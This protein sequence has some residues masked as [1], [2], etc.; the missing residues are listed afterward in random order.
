MMHLSLHKKN[1]IFRHG[2]SL[3]ILVELR[4]NQKGTDDILKR[5]CLIANR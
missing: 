3:E 4:S 2:E 1:T 5:T